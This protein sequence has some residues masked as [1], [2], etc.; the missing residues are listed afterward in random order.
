MERDGGDD[1]DA[2][3]TFRNVSSRVNT[4][5]NCQ[6]TL[7][8]DG[9]TYQLRGTHWWPQSGN[10]PQAGR[11]YSVALADPS[12]KV[13][14]SLLLSFNGVSATGDYRWGIAGQALMLEEGKSNKPRQE[15]FVI[16]ER[17]R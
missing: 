13:Y 16:G 12:G 6:G 5:N 3:L 17:A 14:L 2:T 1:F 10:V 15:W 8:V 9:K 11:F 4:P 7:Q